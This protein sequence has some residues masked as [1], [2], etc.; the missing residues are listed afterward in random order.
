MFVALAAVLVVAGVV[1]LGSLLVP[2]L[3]H[4][5]VS[6]QGAPGL[7]ITFADDSGPRQE[8]WPNS[9]VWWKRYTTTTSSASVTVVASDDAITDAVTC[10]IL[11]NER[12]VAEET[13]DSG[14]VSCSYEAGLFG[15]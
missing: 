2:R 4:V 14:E 8:E 9:S 7:T 1:I 13:S 5:E 6:A 3:N 10:R 12:V 15:F 11:W